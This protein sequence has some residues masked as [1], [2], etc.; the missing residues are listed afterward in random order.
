VILEGSAWGE[1][2]K[3]SSIAIVFKRGEYGKGG[4]LPSIK[5][6]EIERTIMFYTFA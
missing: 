3:A 5:D 2:K 1:K 6:R 4:K